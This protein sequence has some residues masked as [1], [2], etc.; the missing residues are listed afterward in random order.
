MDSTTRVSRGRAEV[1]EDITTYLSGCVMKYRNEPRITLDSVPDDPQK[2]GSGFMSF[3]FFADHFPNEPEAPVPWK[4]RFRHKFH[5]FVE[6]RPPLDRFSLEGYTQLR[7]TW[8]GDSNNRW[9]ML[10]IDLECRSWKFLRKLRGMKV[11][12][13]CYQPLFDFLAESEP[14]LDS[15]VAIIGSYLVLP[16][17]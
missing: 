5:V 8:D 4:Y 15:V 1:L 2:D 9:H 3:N 12:D 7:L 13:R 11:K 16:V 17:M 6:A 10:D 14:A